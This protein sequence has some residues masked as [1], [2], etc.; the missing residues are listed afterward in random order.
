MADAA[1]G[2]M[3]EN[4]AEIAVAN[5]INNINGRNRVLAGGVP[6]GGLGVGGGVGQVRTHM[7]THTHTHAHMHSN[8]YL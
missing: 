5:A 7:H 3:P 1:G 2:G 6:A 4:A 8:A